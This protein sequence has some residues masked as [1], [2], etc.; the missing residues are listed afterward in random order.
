MV[1]G[2]EPGHDESRR[3]H[4]GRRPGAVVPPGDVEIGTPTS[5][6]AISI[7]FLSRGLVPLG[8][9]LAGAIATYFGAPHTVLFMGAACALLAVGML[10]FQPDM[11]ALR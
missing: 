4:S 8:S 5:Q 11:R 9:L 1:A 10:V 7:Y 3:T 2:R 6:D